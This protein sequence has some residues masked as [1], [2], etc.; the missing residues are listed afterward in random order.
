MT[1]V[2][3]TACPGCNG[4]GRC[5]VTDPDCDS[6]RACVDCEQ[7]LGDG[8]VAVCAEPLCG[9]VY[10]LA[11]A[12]RDGVWCEACRVALD[13]GDCDAERERLRHAS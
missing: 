9:E 10:P 8:R 7:C 2:A 4:A 1:G 6:D 3:V 11:E 12:A 5:W 13:R